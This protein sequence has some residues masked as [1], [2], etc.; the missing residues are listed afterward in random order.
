MVNSLCVYVQYLVFVRSGSRE[1]EKAPDDS[2]KSSE[3]QQVTLVDPCQTSSFFSILFYTSLLLSIC[4]VP[5]F[6][7]LVLSVLLVHV[8]FLPPLSLG[9][10][11]QLTSF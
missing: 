4:L 11:D 2:L 6:F 1:R 9:V 5:L 10:L 3:E 7:F 8:F